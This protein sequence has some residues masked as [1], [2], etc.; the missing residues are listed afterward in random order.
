MAHR[1]GAAFRFAGDTSVTA[2]VN[3][4][5]GEPDPTVLREDLDKVP[6]DGDGGVGFGEIETA[7][8][9]VDMRIDDDAAGD[10]ERGSEDDVGGLAR[11]SGDGEELVEIAG[12]FAAK[13]AQDGLRRSNDGFGL[14]IKE[15]G[16]ADDCCDLIELGFGEVA[17]GGVARE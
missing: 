17:D 4:L 1:T 2:E 9:A 14:V 7:G 3:D 16:G 10:A 5:V 8:D 11:R 15:A 6:F 12:D 13:V